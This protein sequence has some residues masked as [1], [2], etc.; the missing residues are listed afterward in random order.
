MHIILHISL[1]LLLPIIA[2][3]FLRPIA[4]MKSEAA[5]KQWL[6]LFY[7]G[8]APLKRAWISLRRKE[9]G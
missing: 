4:G 6:S 8:Q 3:L 1:H 5:G 9:A 7:D 2:K